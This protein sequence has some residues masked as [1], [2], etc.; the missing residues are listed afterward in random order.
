MTSSVDVDLCVIGGEAAGFTIA[1]GAAQLGAKTV[2]IEPG[3]LG[4]DQGSLATQ[5]LRASANAAWTLQNA[6]TFGLNALAPA[7]D[8]KAVF[9]RVRSVLTD[10]APLHSRVRIEG[11]SVEVIPAPAR[12][13]DRRRVE[14]GGRIVRARRF[15]IATGAAPIIP[16]IPGLADGGYRTPATIA[17]LDRV[18]D[19]LIVIGGTARGLELAQGLRRLGARVTLLAT[20]PVLP[21]DDPELVDV[22]RQAL[23]QDGVDL[24]ENVSVAR[25]ERQVSTVIAV[26]GDGERRIEG[27]D[28][29]IAVG[30]AP[31]IHD[32]GLA[33]A[34]V[35]HTASGIAVDGRLRTSNRRIFAVGA[36]VGGDGTDHLA[37]SHAAVVLRNA[38]FRIPSRLDTRAVPRVTFT[39]PALAQVGLSEDD[40][41]RQGVKLRVLRWAL[42]DTDRAQADGTLDGH[43]KVVATPKGR[44]HGA[45]IVGPAAD[46]MINLWTLAIRNRIKLDGVAE[47]IVPYPTLSS[48]SRHAAGSFVTPRLFSERTKSLVRFLA[49]FG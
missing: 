32:L 15:V 40:A 9:A 35:I 12:F 25:I 47:T 6:T 36:S 39:M 46:E 17:D 24:H 45:G 33:A 4:G 30:E 41:R 37:A 11:L 22:V 14:A 49:R 42:A 28:L 26:L 10:V 48:A 5:I 31:H 1:A 34:D 43:V 27:S 23:I 38:L 21:E 29:L 19:H 20:T 3:P 2:L 18:P 13:I 7:S 44:I 16:T 8:G